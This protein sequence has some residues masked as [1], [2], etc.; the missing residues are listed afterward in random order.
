MRGYMDI[1]AIDADTPEHVGLVSKMYVDAGWS[2]RLNEDA[3]R[4]ALKN[5]Y[6]AFGAFEGGEFAGFFRALS[7][8]VSDA[9]LLDLFVYGQYRRRGIALALCRKIVEKLKADDI[10]W[11]TCISTPEGKPV[12][13]RLAGVME[14]HVPFRF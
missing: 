11:I 14:G 5:S 2:D 1:I 4:R 8:G 9:Y 6:C 10:S 3:V 13:S 7:D 12:Y